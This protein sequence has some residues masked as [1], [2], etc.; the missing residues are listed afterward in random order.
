M[1][2]IVG[3][4]LGMQPLGA[5]RLGFIK[6]DEGSR[7]EETLTRFEEPVH[8]PRVRMDA[9]AKHGLRRA[10]PFH[11]RLVLVE[12]RANEVDVSL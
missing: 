8:G 9:E 6:L 3:V 10:A 5:L 12:G 2:R 7:V 11:R 4:R 1:R